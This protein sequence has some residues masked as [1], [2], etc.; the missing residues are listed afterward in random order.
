MGG[1]RNEAGEMMMGTMESLGDEDDGMSPA[2]KAG[3]IFN[4]KYL[5]GNFDQYTAA[6]SMTPN[7]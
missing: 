7:S 5:E 4:G 1:V 2:G 6:Q 3:K